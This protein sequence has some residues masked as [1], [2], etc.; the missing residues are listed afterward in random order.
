MMLSPLPP[1]PLQQRHELPQAPRAVVRA[2]APQEAVGE[3]LRLGRGA[4]ER[5]ALGVVRGRVVCLSPA[6]WGFVLQ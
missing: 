4:R 5:L 3:L 6:A 2:Q 1:S